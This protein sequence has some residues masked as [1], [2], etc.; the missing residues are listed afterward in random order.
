LIKEPLVARQGTKQ[1]LF[2]TD[3][4][5]TVADF[6]LRGNPVSLVGTNIAS[7][8][9]GRSN[10]WQARKTGDMA[11]VDQQQQDIEV[12]KHLSSVP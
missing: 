4:N 3:R 6:Y 9:G 8:M 10:P 12:E 7:I 5:S 11:L 1:L 2:A